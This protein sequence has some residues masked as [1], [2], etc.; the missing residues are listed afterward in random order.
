VRSEIERLQNLLKSPGKVVILT[1]TRPDG[2]AIASLLAFCVCLDHKGF[3]VT[4]FLSDNLPKRYAF[5][6]GLDL[7]TSHFP[8]DADIFIAVDCADEERLGIPSNIRSPK[9]DVNI[10]HHSSNSHFASINIVDIKAASTTFVIQK[11]LVDLDFPITSVVATLLL[12]GLVT[13]TIGFRT[14]NV[15]PEVLCLAAQLQ[16]LGAPLAEIQRRA[17]NE[18]SFAAIRYWGFGLSRVSQKNG[19]VWTCL[20]LGDREKS[21]YPGLDDADLINILSSVEGT[22][23]AV[24]LIEQPRGRVK[25]SWRS[26][27]GVNVAQVA[28]R[29]G[30]GGHHAAAGAMIDGD[31]EKVTHAVLE[32]TFLV[33]T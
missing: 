9:I 7:I 18:K 27:G 32:A 25:V 21:G 31:I 23:I 11:I 13:D 30:G 1:H 8:E 24:I 20:Q 22:R 19:V 28:E 5:L 2:D 17:L 15:T 6:P 10:D 12:T 16:E 33:V 26:P 29:F 14:E 4:G 3:E